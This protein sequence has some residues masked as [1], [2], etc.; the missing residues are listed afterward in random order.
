[1]DT[2]LEVIGEAVADHDLR[3][4]TAIPRARDH[5]VLDLRR[6]DGSSVAGQWF[7][8]PERARRTGGQTQQ[9]AP[10]ADVG[11]LG[12]S[13][14]LVQPVGADRTLTTLHRLAGAPGAELVSHRPEQR[15]VISRSGSNASSTY[16]KVVRTKRL[17]RILVGAR[18]SVPGVMRPDVSR[19]DTDHGSV[20]VAGLP[21]RPLYEILGDSQT[22]D[23]DVERA[24]QRVGAALARLHAT[25]APAALPRHDAEAEYAVTAR[26]VELA[27]AYGLLTHLSVEPGR[28]LEMVHGRLAG[29]GG[30]PG[31]VH[32]DLHDKQ[33]LLAGDAVGMLDFD[34]A[35]TGEAALDLANLAVH[36]EL[37]ARQG[38]CPV[39][40]AAG[41]AAALID[42][43]RP[44]IA[45]RRRIAAYQLATRARLACVYA[46]R[47]AHRHAGA[48]LL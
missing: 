39:E 32:R 11:V 38:R 18:L 30:A 31:L 41:C 40:R 1:M 28:L 43:Y 33:L 37:R 24:G 19:V 26:W 3:L 17:A 15:G 22:S 10:T 8:D 45:V 23:A 27:T 48:A 20:T 42:G 25:P 9:V 35:A 2:V 13:G 7:A 47:P 4:A 46:F 44:S 36:L 14:V 12:S 29:E 16:T 6:P 34:L 21:G 5:L